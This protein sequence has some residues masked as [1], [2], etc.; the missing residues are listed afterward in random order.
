VSAG[1]FQTFIRLLNELGMTEDFRGY[2]R[3]TVFAP[4]DAAFSAVPRN[5]FQ[6]LSSDRELLAKVLAYHAVVG[7]SPLLS[8]DIA[9]PTSLTTLERSEIRLTR[10]GDRLYVNNARVIDRDI[11]ASNGV[12]HAI[13]Q[14]LIPADI[15]T[16]L[17]H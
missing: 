8:R 17:P 11:E 4:T 15:S 16:A 14:V 1:S 6:A 9:T 7:Q 5:V 10:R 12:I 3:F 2:G 13:N